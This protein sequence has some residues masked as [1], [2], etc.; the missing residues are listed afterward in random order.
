MPTPSRVRRV[1][2]ELKRRELTVETVESP[3]PNM[4]RV[5]LTGDALEDFVSASFDDHIKLFFPTDSDTPAMR[6]YTPRAYS[7]AERRLVIEFA[8]HG[9]GP[10]AS[11]SAAAKPGETLTVGGPRG[12]FII[13]TDYDWHLLAGDETALPAIARRLEELP[14]DTRAIVL[15]NVASADRRELPS[16]AAVDLCWVDDDAALLDAARALTLPAGEGY[17]WCAGEANTMAALRK[18]LVDDKGHDRHAIRAAA[19]WKRGAANHH[20]NLE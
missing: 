7:N 1:R 10:A 8:Q 15:L 14:A 3:T 9:D 18:I 20:E 17:A 16:R 19:Y 4:R 12:S 5:T 13:P 6:D 11:W 2:H